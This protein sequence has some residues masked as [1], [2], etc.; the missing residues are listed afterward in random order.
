MC[1]TSAA[2]PTLLVFPPSGDL[3]QPYLS[4]PYLAGHLRAHGEPVLL[5]D[6]NLLGYL[7]L[8]EPA[9][10]R[11]LSGKVMRRAGTLDRKTRLSFVQ[12]EEYFA[13]N[14]ARFDGD[15]LA[16]HALEAQRVL[17]SQDEFFDPDRY[18]WAVG[19]LEGSLRLVSAAHFPVRLSFTGYDLPPYVTNFAE[20]ERALAELPNP[21]LAAYEK[22]LFPLIEKERPAVVGLSMAFPGQLFQGYVIAR[23]IKRRFPNV[24]VTAGGTATAQLVLRMEP[25]ALK[26]FRSFYDSIVVFEGESALLE[27]VRRVRDGRSLEG[28]FNALTFRAS[29]GEPLFAREAVNEDLNALAI[30]DFDGLPLE[31]YLSPHLVLYYAPTRGCYFNKCAFCHYGLAEKSTASYRERD[32]EKVVQDLKA[33]TAKYAT[34]LYYFSGDVISPRWLDKLSQAVVREGV[35]VAWSSDLRPEKTFSTA[36]KSEALRRSGCLAVALGIESASD[37]LLKLMVKG[38]QSGANAE[39]IRHMAEAGIAVQAMTFLGFPTET[40]AEA[41][42]TLDFLDSLSDTVALFFTVDFDMQPGAPVY[43]EPE[44]YGVKKVW[45]LRGDEFRERAKF[46]AEGVAKTPEEEALLTARVNALFRKFGRRLYPYAGSV[47][48]SHTF[49]YFRRHGAGVF[50]EL[51][52]REEPRLPLGAPLSLAFGTRFC[53]ATFDLQEVSDRLAEGRRAIEA[54]FERAGEITPALY[55]RTAGA[56]PGVEPDPTLCIYRPFR[57]PVQISDEV[58]RLTPLVDGAR[59]AE[60]IVDLFPGDKAFARENLERLYAQGIVEAR[61]VDNASRPLQSGRALAAF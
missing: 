20:L 11:K 36:E 44:K 43:H 47:A 55:E 29:D 34:N 27:L 12:Q 58:W 31:K 52:K 13:V 26:G 5:Q 25:T 42:A 19:V 53:K 40:A 2:G 23:E 30:P 61:G 4:L 1:A 59:T 6:L 28:L 54:G 41:N 60:A 33:L 21:F 49:L 46:T 57:L 32:P 50:K 18:D 45:H 8:F 37:R 48:F 56:L 17:R 15:Y 9:A 39:V 51:A 22:H 35:D 16:D 14:A 3:T 7:E 24:H 10:L 38:T